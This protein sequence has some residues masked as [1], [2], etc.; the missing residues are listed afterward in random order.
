MTATHH[1]TFGRNELKDVN[2]TEIAVD[3]TSRKV[4][5][6]FKGFDCIDTGKPDNSGGMQIPGALQIIFDADCE[7]HREADNAL[8]ISKGER[9]V[10]VFVDGEWYSSGMY[11]GK[12]DQWRR[13]IR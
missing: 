3:I 6:R 7:N 5:S 11:D 8:V 10:A 12:H 2:M 9:Q 1:G 13:T 4:L